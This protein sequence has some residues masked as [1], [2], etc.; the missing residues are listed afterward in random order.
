MKN[1]LDRRK[2]RQKDRQT[3]R[4]RESDDMYTVDWDSEEDENIIHR[5]GGRQTLETMENLV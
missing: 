3:D 2:E 5:E 1:K 4:E